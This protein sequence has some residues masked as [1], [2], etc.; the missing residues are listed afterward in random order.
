MSN[1]STRPVQ[2]ALISV[3]N[4]TGI[5]ELGKA[6]VDAGVEILSTGGTAKLLTENNLPVTEV[7]AHTGFPE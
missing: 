7:S 5:L 4:K 1:D 2:R 6:L 3:S